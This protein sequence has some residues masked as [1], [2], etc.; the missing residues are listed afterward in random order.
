MKLSVLFLVVALVGFGAI[1]QAQDS[2]AERRHHN[3]PQCTPEPLSMIGLGIAGLGLLRA[4]SK[5][6][7]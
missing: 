5:K 4:R 6:S 3:P 7:A 1:A 2:S